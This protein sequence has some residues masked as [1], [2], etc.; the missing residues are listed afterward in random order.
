MSLLVPT[1]LGLAALAG[2]LIV[3]YML[4]SKRRRVEVPSTM[5]WNRLGA[6]VS[7]AVPWQP[8]KLTSLLLLQ[9]LIL[10]LFVLSLARPF[11]TEAALLGPHTVFVVDSSGSMAT[12]GRLERALARAGDLAGGAGVSNLISV[13]E[14]GSRAEVLVSFAQTPDAV[15]EALS[16]ITAGGGPADLSDAIRLARGLTT[17]DRPTNLLLFTDGGPAPLAEEPVVG[18]T[19]LPFDESGDDVSLDAI[20]AEFGDGGGVRVLFTATNHTDRT[21]SEVFEIKIDDLA[22]GRVELEL[23]PGTPASK[24]IPVDAPAGAT[25]EV[26]R[27]GAPDANPLDD[28]G[29]LIVGEG[30]SRTVDLGTAPS[31][32]I[33]ALVRSMPRWEEGSEGDVAV[34][35]GGEL[36]DIDR[37]TWIIALITYPEGVEVVE[38]AGNLAVSSQRPGEPLLDQ[39]DLSSVAVADAFKVEAPDWLPIVSAGDV[40]LILLGE[41][42]GYRSVLFTFDITHSDLPLQVGFP[43]LGA[44]I[45]DWLAGAGSGSVSTG[46]AGEPIPLA[47]PAGATVEM[48][49]PDGSVVRLAGTATGYLDT[50][51]P[52]VYRVGYRTAQD[53]VETGPVAVRNFVPT[54]AGLLP[55]DVEV[56][57]G[58]ETEAGESS[59][60][61]EWAPWVIGL[62]LTLMLIEWWMGHQR[63]GLRRD[64]VV[65]A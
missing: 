51:Q 18:A 44:R 29:W 55:R 46:G 26:R 62:V 39:V 41:I 64:R 14:A 36:P 50:A 12:A 35:D 7:S 28:A 47:P 5:L 1:A 8:L 22:A 53:E 56:A 37:P 20:D 54:E 61:R 43:I 13:V 63:P 32:F 58:I 57:P 21:R 10:A 19:H 2:P 25:I 31:P 33:E 65:T 16:T 4:R 24:T 17:P 60:V 49:R 15:K 38:V 34:V 3:L 45:L 23:E 6:P 27:V 42:D 48:T 59:R 9:L 30:P 40:P 52:G 11:A